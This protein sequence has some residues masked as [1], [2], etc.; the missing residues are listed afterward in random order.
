MNNLQHFDGPTFEA[1]V[2]NSADPVVVDFWAEWCPPCKMMEPAVESLADEFAGKVKIGKLDVEQDDV[3]VQLV[4]GGNG[5]LTVFRLADD[6]V[7]LRLQQRVRSRTEARVVVDDQNVHVLIVA[8]RRRA[9][10]TGNR[11][12]QR[13]DPQGCVRNASTCEAKPS[14]S[15]SPSGSESAMKPRRAYV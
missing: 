9:D 5:G 7:S 10:H 1:D 12:I 2:L 6:V 13:P 4:S 15:S 14:I 11:T 3:R 8:D